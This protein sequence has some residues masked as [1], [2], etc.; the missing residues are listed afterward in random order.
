M[1]SYNLPTDDLRDLRRKHEGTETLRKSKKQHAIVNGVPKVPD[2]GTKTRRPIIKRLLK[3]FS[4]K[5]TKE[6]VNV[7]NDEINETIDEGTLLDDFNSATD[8]QI[9][10]HSNIVLQETLYELRDDRDDPM[11]SNERTN[12]QTGEQM[13]DCVDVTLFDGIYEDI[14]EVTLPNT[15]WG[16]HRDPNR[17]FIVFS[18]FDEKTSSTSKLIRLDNGMN[19]QG[20]NT[21]IYIRGKVVNKYLSNL[22]IEYLTDLV[23]QVDEYRI[24]E[25]F[26]SNSKCGVVAVERNLCTH[27]HQ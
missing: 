1:P 20:W 19:A 12:I 2:E 15:L 21:H 5:R 4:K 3:D 13:Y 10:E 16:I 23:N 18:Y 7:Q 24:C 25:K 22:S 8:D 11:K 14:Y 17:T 6:N 26:D 27:C 9:D